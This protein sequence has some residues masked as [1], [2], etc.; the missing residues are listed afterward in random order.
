MNFGRVSLKSLL[1]V[2]DAIAWNK[3]CT[4]SDIMSFTGLSKPTVA[5]AIRN[6]VF[7]DL[8]KENKQTYGISDNF[9]RN[10]TYE[11]KK[12]ILREK[13]QEWEMFQN[14]YGFLV[15]SDG[16]ASA[17]RKTLA[18]C[19]IDNKYSS[20]MKNMLHFAADLGIL[21]F[22][23]QEYSTNDTFQHTPHETELLEANLNSEMAAKLFLTK[24]LTPE[25]FHSL[26]TPEKDRLTKAILFYKTDPESS[27]QYAGQALE[28]YL[29]FIGI[30][31]GED[32]TSCDG[33]GQIAD[34][35]AG[36]G[37]LI[38]HPR[39]RDI[40]KSVASIRNSSAHDRDKLTS[41]PW[42]KTSEIALS[43]FLL[44]IQLIKSIHVWVATKSQIL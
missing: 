31:A 11:A 14:L 43:N 1:E 37:R 29:R 19:K 20:G 12:V 33:L 18:F 25:L 21:V 2:L 41:D 34:Y 36:K 5:V 15:T 32:L 42:I 8:V 23:G 6:S 10:F 35:L 16:Y 44:V 17:I 7:L 38:I 3:N 22:D 27:C 4:L 30:N 26:D 39:H 9:D 40:A 24:T 13:L 28:N